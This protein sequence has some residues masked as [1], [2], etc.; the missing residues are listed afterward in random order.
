MSQ[1][2]DT[3]GLTKYK[4]LIFDLDDTL[5]DN[6]E[7][8]RAAFKR[9]LKANE[10]AYSD[11]EYERWYAIDKKFWHD[12]Q[13]GLIELP[14]KF[15]HESGTKSDEYLDWVRAQ[16]VLLYFK[17]SISLQRA[18]A[19]NH[20]FMN[21]LTEEVNAIEGAHDVLKYLSEKYTILIA[22]NGPKVATKHKL[23]RI[24]C[25]QFVR[26]VLSA[27][28]FG[29]MKPKIEFFEAIE[30]KYDDFNHGDYL[31]IGDTLKSD[32][33]FGMNAGID[34]CWFN[35]NHDALDSDYKHTFVINKLRE[36]MGLL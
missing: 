9:M 5:I 7:N 10:G 30:Q 29:Y 6:R 12:W 17:H 19:L 25:L 34:S 36:L 35:R 24:N 11:S 8:V 20:V 2:T 13:D 1:Q 14:Q 22:T 28:M 21:A 31:I 23:E 27:D 15:R 18:I 26:E 32:V 33:G 3:K 16:R 4:I